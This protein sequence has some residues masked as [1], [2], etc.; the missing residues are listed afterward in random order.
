M[1]SQDLATL[2][3]LDNRLLHSKLKQLRMHQQLQRS[4]LLE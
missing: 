2:K 3:L 4:V 1:S